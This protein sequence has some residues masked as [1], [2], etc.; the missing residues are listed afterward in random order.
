MAQPAAVAQIHDS[1][2]PV[3]VGNMDWDEPDLL[4][5]EVDMPEPVL[6]LDMTHAL[7]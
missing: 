3:T 4:G 1:E 7:Q 2:C 6:H 5:K